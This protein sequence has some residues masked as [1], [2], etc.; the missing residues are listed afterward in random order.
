[1]VMRRTAADST[2]AGIAHQA[3]GAGRHERR[4]NGGTDV[5]EFEVR[6]YE[7]ESRRPIV[8]TRVPLEASAASL[9]RRWQA[10]RPECRIT[11][12]ETRQPRP[13]ALA[14]VE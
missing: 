12:V 13:T 5:S 11:V 8:F 9:A 7:G 10:A 6:M 14:T 2:N 1:M 3:G 4:A